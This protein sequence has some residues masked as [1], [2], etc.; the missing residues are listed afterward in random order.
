MS[1]ICKNIPLSQ[2][3]GE[4]GA[5][6]LKEIRPSYH[7]E[8]GK[9]TDQLEG[10]TYVVVNPDSFDRFTVKD[11]HT[12]PVVTPEILKANNDVGKHVYVEIEGATVTPY[13][14]KSGSIEDSIKIT[15]I[16]RVDE[17]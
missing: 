9:K 16:K 17:P 15:S 11:S 5:F 2:L 12:T 14:S 7:Y 6:V 8:A 3:I 1:S 13:V 10:Y 4:Y